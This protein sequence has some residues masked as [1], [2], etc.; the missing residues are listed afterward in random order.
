MYI[1]IHDGFIFLNKKLICRGVFHH[2]HFGT[3]HLSK[4]YQ[5]LKKNNASLIHCD[6][7]IKYNE[8]YVT[9]YM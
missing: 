6:A 5:T 2:L 8:L 9:I 7:D 1:Y 3:K 4:S